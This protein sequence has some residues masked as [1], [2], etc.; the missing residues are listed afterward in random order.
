MTTIAYRDGII[1]GD[2][3]LNSRSGFSGAV[4][5]ITMH[6]ETGLLAGYAGAAWAGTLFLDAVEHSKDP[7]SDLW[8]P[9]DSIG[10]L[11]TPK[12]V[13]TLVQ[14]DVFMVLED[15]Y[16]A[17]GSGAGYAMAAMKAG[18]GAIDAVMIA[19]SIDPYTKGPF[20]SLT[21]HR[22]NV[23]SFEKPKK[24]KGKRKKGRKS[25]QETESGTEVSS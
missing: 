5:K 10:M 3:T 14:E 4:R 12:G 22:D 6:E 15:T 19:A 23:V 17:I 25:E 16:Y 18:A 24:R 8:L 7:I 2:R 21:N 9:Q 11:V 13:I 20:D 1:C